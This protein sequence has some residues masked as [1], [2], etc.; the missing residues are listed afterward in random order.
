MGSEHKGPGPCGGP[1]DISDLPTEVK[2]ISASPREME[3]VRDVWT[4]GEC[5]KPIAQDSPYFGSPDGGNFHPVCLDA[6][7]KRGGLL[8]GFWVN[9]SSPTMAPGAWSPLNNLPEWEYFDAEMPPDAFV[10][11]RDKEG[12]VCGSKPFT[13]EMNRIGAFGWELVSMLGWNETNDP[14]DQ[15]KVLLVL[16]RRRGDPRP[17][18]AGLPRGQGGSVLCGVGTPPPA[19]DGVPEV[20]TEGWALSGPNKA[21]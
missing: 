11:P 7:H 4:C 12:K 3:F 10:T 5:K 17:T 9:T 14:A 13:R 8:R 21:E 16:K 1:V 2:Q 18:P 15:G 19:D 20:S 6:I